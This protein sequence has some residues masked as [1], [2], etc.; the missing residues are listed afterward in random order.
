MPR[1]NG[2]VQKFPDRQLMEGRSNDL[3]EKTTEKRHLHTESNF[4]LVSF[5]DRSDPILK[6]VVQS[7]RYIQVLCCIT[8]KRKCSLYFTLLATIFL[9]RGS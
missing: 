5:S 6:N 9:A 4:L 1:G 2:N 7:M 3:R 8:M